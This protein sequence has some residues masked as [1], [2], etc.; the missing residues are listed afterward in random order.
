VE[1][2]RVV[3]VGFSAVQGLDV[4]GPAD[5]FGAATWLAPPG[6]SVELVARTPDPIVTA[7]GIALLP[8]AT[9]SE[10]RGPIDT[11]IVAGGIGTREVQRDPALIG[12]LEAAAARSRRVTSVCTGALLLAAAGLLDGRR[13]TTHWEACDLL[14]R[15]YP[16]VDVEPDAIF[17]RDGDVITSAGVTAGM[18][19]ALALVEE[20]LGQSI[21]LQ[22]AR[23]LVMYTRR[24]GGQSQ[25]S[26]ALRAQAATRDP[27]RELQEW[28]VDHL[29]ADLSVPALAARAHMSP[30]NF[31]RAFRAE[32]G[33]TPAAY[34]RGLR[35]ERARS[36]LEAGDLQVDAV[37]RVCGFGTV[38]AMRRTFRDTLGV[39]PAAYR[40]RFRSTLQEAA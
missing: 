9:L 37:A 14:A 3:I 29:D 32:T 31:A 24:G 21:A 28:I 18:D 40:A 33:L 25:F 19:M 15:K 7:S 17:V 8:Q 12:W 35:V 10:C 4:M 16:R 38:E 11:L 36:A 34:V 13:A 23:E 2:R 26:N 5:V 6:Y 39:G 1:P 27:L 30:R 22:S 20:D